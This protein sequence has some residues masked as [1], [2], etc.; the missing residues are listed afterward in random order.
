[1]RN[2]LVHRAR[3]TQLRYYY[4]VRRTTGPGLEYVLLLTRDPQLTEIEAFVLGPESTL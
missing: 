2:L 1:M 3:R 4:R